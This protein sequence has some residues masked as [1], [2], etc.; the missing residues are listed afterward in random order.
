MNHRH[1]TSRLELGPGPLMRS[2][3]LDPQFDV[4][5]RHLT[6][7]YVS[8]ELALVRQQ[9]AMGHLSEARAR[10]LERILASLTADDLDRYREQSMS[11]MAF[12]LELC[13]ED[14]LSEPVPMWH[15]DRSR[16]DYQA[17]AQLMFARD[18]MRSLALG[19]IASARAVCAKAAQHTRTPFPGFTHLQAAQVISPGFYLAALA[20][21]LLDSAADLR[22]VFDAADRCPL[23][24]GAMA[25]QNLAWDRTALAREL[26]F[27]APQDHALRAVAD[28]RWALDTAASLSGFGVG[29][30]RFVTDLMAW[31]GSAYR[32]VGLPDDL[33]GISSAMPQKKNLPLLER[34]RGRTAHLF[35]A[36]A[37]IAAAQ[38]N[39]SYSNSVE[40]GKEASSVL[41]DLFA[42]AR[43]VLRL[44][45]AVTASIAFD[46]ERAAAICRQEFLGGFR[47]AVRLSVEEQVPWRTAQVIAGRLIS[48]AE[49]AGLTPEAVPPSLLERAA[50]ASGHTFA[51]PEKLLA[52][53][54][55]PDDDLHSKATGGSAHPDAVAAH[56]TRLASDADTMESSWTGAEG[57]R[58]ADVHA[59]SS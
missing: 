53:V 54:F 6:P 36:Y 44:L 50:A 1:F 31:S 32:L 10:E 41:P 38:R 23:G 3:V 8:I 21:H 25:G 34:L 45:D 20:G 46:R 19:M 37:D 11:D 13:V 39:C 48:D 49:T 47:L 14:R 40:V 59:P 43:S 33:A 51:D 27:T 42:A 16:N 35:G 30:S 28:R 52:R 24:A 9:E 57:T 26:G 4:E 15:V 29:L 56:L 18:E 5:L 17:C 12:A 2:D 22:T 55:D 7:R 58:A